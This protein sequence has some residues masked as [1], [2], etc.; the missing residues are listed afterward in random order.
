MPDAM[1]T[2]TSLAVTI[3]DTTAA[4]TA[5]L[6]KAGVSAPTFAV[7]GTADYPKTPEVMGLR[8]QLMD[9]VADMWRLTLGPTDMMVSHPLF[10]S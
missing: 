8:V 5:Q 10:V 2:L 4:L 7:D 1:L 6:E 9:A 3:S